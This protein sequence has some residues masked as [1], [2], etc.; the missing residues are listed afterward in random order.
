MSKVLELIIYNKIIDFVH[1]RLSKLQFGF[2]KGRSCLTQLLTCFSK[3]FDSIDGNTPCDVIYLDFKKAFD[4][5][6]HPELSF[7]QTVDFWYNWSSLVLVQILP[8]RSFSSCK[9]WRLFL[10]PV[11]C[12]IGCP[13]GKCARSPPFSGVHQWPPKCYNLL[14]YLSFLPMT[15]NHLGLPLLCSIS[16]KTL[17]IWFHGATDGVCCQILQN[18]L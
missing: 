14:L 8:Q 18:V 5:I 6:P 16:S 10:W 15:Q 11:T 12:K 13:A 7:V 4:S 2:L 17:I 9:H 1:P 3:V